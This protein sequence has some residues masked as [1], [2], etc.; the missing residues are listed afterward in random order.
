MKKIL[1]TYATRTGSEKR[2]V[3]QRV[4]AKVIN[5]KHVRI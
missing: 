4:G 5:R 2:Q 1:V 3:P